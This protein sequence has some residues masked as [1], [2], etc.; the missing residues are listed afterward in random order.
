VRTVQFGRED[1][2]DILT[3]YGKMTLKAHEETNCLT[4]VMISDAIGWARECN[5][6]GPL[7]GIP[8]SLKDVSELPLCVPAAI[9]H[10]C[11]SSKCRRS[12]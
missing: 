9:A 3:S 5:K 10:N 1:P 6:K 7:A 4:E 11:A 12:A 8:V 2:V